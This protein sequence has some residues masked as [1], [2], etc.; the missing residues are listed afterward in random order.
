MD[1]LGHWFCQLFDVSAAVVSFQALWSHLGGD[2]SEQAD[3]AVTQL[4]D[5]DPDDPMVAL[6]RRC[7]V[8]A[9]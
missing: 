6:F 2:Q 5:A 3:V 4:D 7:A 8:V 9:S 1:L